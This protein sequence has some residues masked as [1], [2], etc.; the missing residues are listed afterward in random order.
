VQR[1]RAVVEFLVV[2]AIA[3]VPAGN[4]N[5]SSGNSPASVADGQ[6]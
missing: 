6:R 3:F 5:A 1:E 2:R 4:C